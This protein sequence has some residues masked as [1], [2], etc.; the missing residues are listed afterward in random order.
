MVKVRKDVFNFLM[1]LRL[2]TKIVPCCN[3]KAK[4]L[5]ANMN[6]IQVNTNELTRLHSGCHGNLVAIAMRY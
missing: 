5:L 4:S 2:I 1:I 6:S 3:N